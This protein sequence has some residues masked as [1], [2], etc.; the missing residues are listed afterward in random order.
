MRRASE[1]AIELIEIISS[2]EPR[3]A[4]AGTMIMVA[5]RRNEV[6]DN[7][8]IISSSVMT[9]YAPADS[10][11]STPSIRKGCLKV[12]ISRRERMAFAINL[13]EVLTGLRRKERD[14]SEDTSLIALHPPG[15]GNFEQNIQVSRAV[16]SPFM[17]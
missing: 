17:F 15:I 11:G 13:M 12:M 7:P 9:S 5:T 1:R 10:S 3:G 2:V 16:I 8:S 4:A 6:N 14:V